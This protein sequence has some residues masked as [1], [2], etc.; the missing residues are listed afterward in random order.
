MATRKPVIQ[1]M[2]I[3]CS[4]KDRRKRKL[5]TPRAVKER[6]TTR[7]RASRSKSPFP[8]RTDEMKLAAVP[9]P[10]AKKARAR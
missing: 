3:H 9:S 2:N 1:P 7:H 5:M 4:W 10:N 6:T 8:F